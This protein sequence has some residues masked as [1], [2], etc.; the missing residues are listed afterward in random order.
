MNAG[1]P[2]SHAVFSYFCCLDFDSKILL[3]ATRNIKNQYFKIGVTRYFELSKI[4][5]YPLILKIFVVY[6]NSKHI[7]TKEGSY[8]RYIYQYQ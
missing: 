7:V 2:Q 3:N 6:L 8:A 4:F 5:S 1:F